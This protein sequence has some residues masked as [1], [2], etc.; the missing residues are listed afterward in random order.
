MQEAENQDTAKI[1]ITALYFELTTPD[2]EIERARNEERFHRNAKH[3]TLNDSAFHIKIYILVARV[4][5]GRGG[6]VRD[7]VSSGRGGCASSAA[8]ANSQ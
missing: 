1:L 4:A 3:F 5:C 6:L 2:Y 7:W 8:F